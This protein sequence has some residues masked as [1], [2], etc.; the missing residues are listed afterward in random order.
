MH[1]TLMQ[2]LGLLALLPV[3]W[4]VAVGLHELG[5][6]LAGRLQ[7]FCLHWLTIGPLMW[8]RQPAGRLRFEWNRKLNTAGG[9]AL[10]VPP[11]D[12]RLRERFRVF[13]AGGPLASLAWGA[14]GVGLYTLLPAAAQGTVPVIALALSGGISLLLFVVTIIPFH[15]GGFA[16]DGMRL[17]NLSRRGPKQELEV[18]M[19]TASIRSMVGIRPRE[20]NRLALEAAAALHVEHPLKCHLSYYLYLHYLDA[21]DPVAAGQQL[22]YYR[23]HLSQVPAALQASGWLEAA[24]FSAAYEHDATAARAYQAEA[25][26][27][28]FTPADQPPRVEAALARLAGDAERARTQAQA[29]LRELPRNLDQGSVHLYRE[30]LQ[31]TVRWAEQAAVARVASA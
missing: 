8:R 10:S 14:L 21:G 25:K 4:L 1:W 23:Q 31:D 28:A 17:L 5:H 7:G 18:S 9:L 11:D 13:A 2:K 12:V 20:L 29:A 3:A 27:S 24:F 30:W 26:L 15:T 6:A 19:L 22:A 16:S